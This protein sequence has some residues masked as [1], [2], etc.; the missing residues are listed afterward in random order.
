[1]SKDARGNRVAHPR[2]APGGA[3]GKDAGRDGARRL[4]EFAGNRGRT[5]AVDRAAGVIR[6][7]K[8]LGAISANGR[9]YAPQALAEAVKLYEGRPVNIDHIDGGRRSYR[10][11]IGRIVGVRLDADG[12]YGDLVVNPKHPLAEQL[13]WDAE[14]CPE[15]VGLSHD[16]EGRTRLSDGKVIV[17]AIKAVRSVDLVAEPATTKGLFEGLAAAD[18]PTAA[19]VA[20]AGDDEPAGD[21]AA[22]PPPSRDVDRLPDEMFAL[23]LPGGVRIGQRTFPLSKRYFPID[24]P[25]AVARSLERI[26][27]NNKLSAHHLAAARSRALEAAR[28]MGVDLSRHTSAKESVMKLDELTIE[29]LK[30]SRPDL[31]AELR[32][33]GE[34][35]KELVR[36]KEERDRLAGQLEQIERRRKALDEIKRAGLAVEAVPESLLE[37]ISAAEADAQKKMIADLARLAAPKSAPQ[38]LRPT[39]TAAAFEDRVR[40][41][42]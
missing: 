19:A 24:T 39:A 21:D 28:R 16:A 17:E 40:A 32:A 29:Q 41:W 2:S 15:N 18:E 9:I 8:V 20:P 23:V 27:R 33:A 14:H 35:E 34:A 11:R 6:G 36:L 3:G 38:S 7:V 1:M 31:V 10:D 42:A 26:A 37:A 5:L 22:D 4:L 25:A 12:I 13:F 30:E